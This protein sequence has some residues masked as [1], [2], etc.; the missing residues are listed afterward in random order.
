MNQTVLKTL[1]ARFTPR[2]F[3]FP[4]EIINVNAMNYGPGNMYSP[5]NAQG[6]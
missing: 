5:T 3:L 6:F 2:D 1:R 4:P